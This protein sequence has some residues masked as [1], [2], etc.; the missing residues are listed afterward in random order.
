MKRD[1]LPSIRLDQPGVTLDPLEE[2]S[3]P[4]LGAIK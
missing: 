1:H 2:F 3:L 4:D